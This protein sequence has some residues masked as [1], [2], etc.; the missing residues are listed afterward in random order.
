MKRKFYT[1]DMRN[2]ATP[3]TVLRRDVPD[4][5]SQ[6]IEV[7]TSCCLAFGCNHLH[8]GDDLRSYE[9]L[10][11]LIAKTTAIPFSELMLELA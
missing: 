4:R 5:P 11:K 6:V 3:L 10:L 1:S 8:G 7:G 2:P 9:H